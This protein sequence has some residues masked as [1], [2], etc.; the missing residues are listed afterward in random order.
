MAESVA[1]CASLGRVELVEAIALKDRYAALDLDTGQPRH[2]APRKGQTEQLGRR[3]KA[4]GADAVFVDAP[5]RPAQ[6][7]GLAAAWGGVR[8]FDRFGLIL[9]VCRSMLGP[10]FSTELA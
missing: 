10:G 4:I 6:L 3:L 9:Q 5:L 1:L 2:R 7:Q 8:V